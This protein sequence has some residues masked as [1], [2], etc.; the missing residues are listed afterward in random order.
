MSKK[1][2]L[3][4]MGRY[5]PG[6]RDGGPV[7]S[8]QNLTDRLGDDYDFNILTCDRDRGDTKPYPG[9]RKGALNRVGNARVA[10]VKPHGF[11]FRIIKK[12][13]D[14]ADLIYLCGCFNDYARKTLLMKRMG[15][16]DKPVLVAAMGLFAHDEF[17]I[18]YP[19]KKAY[20]T[21][22]DR[23]GCFGG[24][25]WSCSSEQEIN[26]VK[27][28]IRNTGSFY[29]ARDL[30]VK[31]VGDP[32]AKG[33]AAGEL[34]LFYLGRIAEVKN[35]K[36][37]VKALL[38]TDTEGL[39]I[40]FSIYGGMDDPAY[41][42]ECRELLDRLPEN[43][44]WEYRGLIPSDRVVETLRADEHVLIMDSLGENYGHAIY[45]AL[46]AGCPVLISDRTSWH[47]V[48]ENGAG[49]EC[50]LEDHSAFGR[51]IRDY[52]LMDRETFG[53]TSEAAFAYARELGGAGCESGYRRM[54]EAAGET[55]I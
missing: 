19:K 53:R 40:S 44:S 6:F 33:K 13:S 51:H 21:I 49:F 11:S 41:Y 24:V 12:L 48:E 10:Y 25:S 35:L 5:L 8:I 50:G 16:L 30:P 52:A 4:I 27:R 39:R 29:V 9:I 38:H 34:R 15:M 37:A 47:G 2:I 7:R 26:D 31:V 36:G 14:R 20:T 1:R 54:F 28:E 42:E 23:T 46:L 43:V 17:H 22:M 55:V 3:I 18:K 32:P 45:E